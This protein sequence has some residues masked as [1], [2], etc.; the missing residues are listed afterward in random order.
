[1]LTTYITVTQPPPV[2]CDFYLYELFSAFLLFSGAALMQLP[3]AHKGATAHTGAAL[4]Q[5][6]PPRSYITNVWV[7]VVSSQRLAAKH[8]IVYGHQISRHKHESWPRQ[9]GGGGKAH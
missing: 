3:A 6:G 7:R 9:R 1:M 8:N 2:K 5:G 4:L